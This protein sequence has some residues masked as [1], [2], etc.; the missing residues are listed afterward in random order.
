MGLDTPG[1]ETA[2]IDTPAL[3][4]GEFKDYAI[5]DAASTDYFSLAA[6]PDRII[7]ESQSR[8]PE[9]QRLE[10]QN[11][12]VLDSQDQA[13]PDLRIPQSRVPESQG[14]ECQNQSRVRS[15]RVLNARF[16]QSRFLDSLDPAVPGHII[17]QSHSLESWIPGILWC[18]VLESQLPDSQTPG[19][20]LALIPGLFPD[21]QTVASECG[22]R[23]DMVRANMESSKD[24]S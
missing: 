21:S 7:L 22:T 1:F 11:P 6:V 9:S 16:L 5:W 8:V 19:L 15:S 20:L 10:C 4:T 23:W 13:V 12:A 18:R 17:L 3:E 2:G 14:L 24:F